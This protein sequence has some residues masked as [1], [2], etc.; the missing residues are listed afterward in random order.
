MAEEPK[1]DK[2]KATI[3]VRI[4][5]DLLVKVD[6]TAVKMG[7]N[8]SA[9]IIMVLKK[10]LSELSQAEAKGVEGLKEVPALP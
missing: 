1:E 5:I 9:F 10:Y 8:R 7:M 3:S 4:P 2:Y 6:E